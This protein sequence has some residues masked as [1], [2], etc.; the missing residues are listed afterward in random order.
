[1]KI[2][3]LS[4]PLALKGGTLFNPVTDTY[5]DVDLLIVN[6]KI[7]TIGEFQVDGS[8]DIL[9][10]RDRIITMGFC[11]IHV[12]FREPGRED[13]ETLETG[14]RAALAGGYTRVCCMPNTNP[15][16]DTPEAVR[17]IIEKSR[18]L[19]VH[20]HPIGAV[21]KG[22][23][24]REMTEMGSMRREGAVAFSDDG[25]PIE[26]GQVMRL[27]M[28][29][30]TM[31]GVPIINHAEDTAL[32]CDG[33]MNEG[34]M[35]TR[36][37]LPGNPDL[38]ES[39]MVNR[40]LE[41]AKLTGARVHVPHV[42]SAKSVEQIRQ[43]KSLGVNVTAEVSPHHLFFN[44]TALQTYDTN[45]KVAPPIR[46]ESDRQ[47]LIAGLRDGT[48]DCIATDHAPHTIEEKESTF[49]LA[50]FG[51]IGLEAGFGASLSAVG[52]SSL[53]VVLKSLTVNPRRVMGFDCE[54]LSEGSKVELVILDPDRSW[55]FESEHIH[56]RSEN[57][58]YVGRTLTGKPIAVINGK[59]LAVM[60]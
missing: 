9:D 11:D 44:D 4:K 49:D 15:P 12:H 19:P 57:C 42:S 8:M 60:D 29:Y 31:V 46:D 22:R 30:S 36:L 54:L 37:G 48:L 51:L 26:D 21:T 25:N 16:L 3:R 17:F 7:K 2:S 58:P 45:L 32:R 18:D 10:C 53:G 55:I 52:K 40:D 33:V 59:T 50:P 1:M 35:S 14:S 23:D 27:A 20:I 34:V 47:A 13:K 24:G 43:M 41:L 56:S 5:R 6:G 38:A 39:V 28:E